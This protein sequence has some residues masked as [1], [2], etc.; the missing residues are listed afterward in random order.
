MPMA[1]RRGRNYKVMLGS[2]VFFAALLF[3]AS[4]ALP[5]LTGLRVEHIPASASIEFQ[6][7]MA[8]VPSTA[9][10]VDFANVSWALAEGLNS[11][12]ENTLLNIF[13]TGQTLTLTNTTY[14]VSYG[15]PNSNPNNNETGVDIFRPQDD[16]YSSLQ[17][18]IDASSLVG[19]QVYRAVTIYYVVNNVTAGD[20]ETARMAFYD[21]F[22][23]Y[24]QGT[25]DP[26]SQVR[27]GLDVALNHATSLFTNRTVQLS[28][29]AVAGNSTNYLALHYLGYGAEISGSNFA[30]KAISG[31]SNNFEA[32]YAFGFNTSSLASSNA[33]LVTSTYLHG[34]DYYLLDNYV[35]AKVPV[36]Q[37]ELFIELM[38]F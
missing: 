2:F 14:L 35:V 18:A 28:V 6:P 7:W 8:L 19:R 9:D 12:T 3:G 21:G 38:G 25:S 27:A 1:R 13:Q 29:Y 4:L 20:L 31:T 24:S 33:D 5:Y 16:V 15:I 26:T 23:I 11:S 17:S 37:E 30:A 34:L 36:Y 32:L 22:I 10:T